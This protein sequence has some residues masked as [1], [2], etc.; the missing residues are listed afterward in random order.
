MNDTE[1]IV[2]RKAPLLA[3]CLLAITVFL[4]TKGFGTVTEWIA[5]EGN[6][7]KLFVIGTQLLAILVPVWLTLRI[8]HLPARPALGLRAP[9]MVKTIVAVVVGF[10]LIYA[11]ASVLPL[12]L[13]PSRQLMSKTGSIVL[14]G[15][16]PEFLLSFLTVSVVASV[17]DEFFYRG[18]LFQG[19]TARHGKILAVLLTALLTALFHNLE[20]FKFVHSFLMGLIFAASVAWTNSVWTSVILHALHNSLALLPR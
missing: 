15:N 5:P 8:L 12:F 17:A 4:L 11:V 10:V 14:Y 1:N 20:P 7:L 9:P 3:L 6:L 18:I 2:Q 13:Q 16:L 19:I